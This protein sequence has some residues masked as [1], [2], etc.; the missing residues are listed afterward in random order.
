MV[1]WVVV[2]PLT[3]QR[4]VGTCCYL[5]HRLPRHQ[6]ILVEALCYQVIDAINEDFSLFSLQMATG[7]CC[8]AFAYDVSCIIGN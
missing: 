4:E 5:L 8:T 2:E 6:H 1:L 7:H 3:T